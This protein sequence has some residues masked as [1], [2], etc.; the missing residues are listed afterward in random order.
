M[1]SKCCR[2]ITLS[3]SVILLSVMKKLTSDCVRNANKS[4]DILNYTTVREVDKWSRIRIRDCQW[5]SHMEPSAT[6]T[7]VT[8][9]VREHLQAG[10]ENAP[11]L[12]RS[13]PLRHLHDSGAGY[14]YPDLLTYLPRKVNKFFWLVGPIT[15]PSFKEIGWLLLQ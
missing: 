5:T 13:A 11:V 8:K 9:P 14:R 4:L 2:F 1:I 12:D 3:S 6:R 7:N 15:A 10:T